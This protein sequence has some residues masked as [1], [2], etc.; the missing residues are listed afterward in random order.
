MS[1][2]RLFLVCLHHPEVQ[3]ALILGKR[4]GTGYFRP[5]QTREILEWMEQHATCGGDLDHFAI[6]YEKPKNWDLAVKKPVS[7]A[8]HLALVPNNSFEPEKPKDAG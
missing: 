5:P 2:N 1:E 6:A 7:G 3:H 8:V 4:L